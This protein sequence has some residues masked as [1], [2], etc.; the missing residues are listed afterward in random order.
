M[1]EAAGLPKLLNNGENTA[2]SLLLWEKGAA[3]AQSAT[4]VDEE[5]LATLGVSSVTTARN[6]AVDTFTLAVR[7]SNT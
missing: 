4:A 7:E 3:V 1:R 2:R 5:L 6:A